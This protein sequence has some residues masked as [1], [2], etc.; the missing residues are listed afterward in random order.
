MSKKRKFQKKFIV[1]P[2]VILIIAGSVTSLLVL[3]KQADSVVKVVPASELGGDYGDNLESIFTMGTLQKGSVQNVIVND[4]L[5][6]NSVKVE[7]GDT[8]KR[9]DTLIEY[10]TDIL[11]LNIESK[12]TE[13]DILANSI[14]IAENELATL[15]GLIPSE[16]APV[17][18]KP[19]EAPTDDIIIEDILP[20]I[21][22][23]EKEITK[24]TKPLAGNGSENSPFIFNVCE[25]AVVKKDYMQYLYGAVVADTATKPTE[26][27]TEN[28]TESVTENVTEGITEKAT[29]ARASKPIKNSKYAMFH[30][31]NENGVLLYSW[32]VD[33]T[34]LTADDVAD[35]KCS[36]GVVITAD[37]NIF[38]K[39]G[40]NLFATLVTYSNSIIDD[41]QIP[42]D[43]L[44]E[45]MLGNI[46]EDLI[47]NIPEDM[48]GSLVDEYFA[49][50]ADIPEEYQDI[51]SEAMLDLEGGIPY[52]NYMYTQ[53]ELQTMISAKQAEVE[54][55]KFGKRQVEIDL[56]HDK[57]LLESGNEVATIN[58]KVT[59]V[60]KSA[61][62]AIVN[63]AYIT[64]INDATTNVI[65]T[66]SEADLPYVTVG[67]I[68]DVT[69]R[70]NRENSTGL[71]TSISQEASGGGYDMFGS[72]D[73]TIS[74]FDITV[75]LKEKIEIN[76]TD[77]IIMSIKTNSNNESLWVQTAFIRTENGKS[78]VL[79]ANEN[80]ILEKRYVE[81]GRRYF[82]VCSEVKSGLS[83][84]D[85]VALPYGKAKEGMPTVDAEYE[86]VES[87][88]L[89]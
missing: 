23:Y 84:D 29:E 33:G 70:A 44:P 40:E 79:V 56:S 8:V 76:E 62:E 69:N 51:Q 24:K 49:G 63:G 48:L 11:Q 64:I 41:E 10:N 86:E 19:T 38:V 78:Y 59:F 14:K 67:M 39:Q 36:N 55:L 47:G 77:E 13:I 58:G 9:G 16:N 15:K 3:K 45:D 31:Y 61:E 7:K 74:Y 89:F 20:E 82:D 30:I 43:E 87:G 37:G 75:E 88:F 68:V 32:L 83:P 52:K 66:V 22:E 17:V 6:I 35:W 57:K 5:S 50:N 12:Q 53:A 26:G 72:Y 18:E 73:D 21:V 46:P 85:R 71:I 2:L 54:E 80:N 34:R 28:A 4:T 42:F 81:I 1:L 65:G 60:A 25:E 27:T